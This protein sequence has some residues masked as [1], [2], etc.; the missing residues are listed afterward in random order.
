MLTASIS[1]KPNRMKKNREKKESREKHYKL[2]SYATTAQSDNIWDICKVQE[3]A[4]T[5]LELIYGIMNMRTYKG[6]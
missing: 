5:R 6:L 2:Y 1:N 4:N 3:V